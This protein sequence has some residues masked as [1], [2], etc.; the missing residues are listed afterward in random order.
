ML[1]GIPLRTTD[2]HRVGLRNSLCSFLE[3]GHLIK[4]SP[5]K[6]PILCLKR[7][8]S[9]YMYTPLEQHHTT[10]KQTA[11]SKGSTGLGKLCWRRW[12]L[13]KAKIGTPYYHILFAY[14]EIPQ[15]AIYQF[16]ERFVVHL[17]FLKKGGRQTKGAVKVW[18]LMFWLLERDWQ[19]T[20]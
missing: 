14:R 2:A 8:T 3:W 4:F 15:A 5:I 16:G 7:Y 13:R 18:Y 17:I 19:I 10:L 1:P 6:E 20:V 11:L 12:F 9:Y